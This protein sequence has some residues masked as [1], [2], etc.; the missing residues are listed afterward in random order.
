MPTILENQ[1]SLIKKYGNTLN[2]IEKSNFIKRFLAEFIYSEALKN[3]FNITV[4]FDDVET[5]TS[6]I[7]NSCLVNRDIKNQITMMLFKLSKSEFKTEIKGPI[8]CFFPA[9]MPDSETTMALTSF[10]ICFRFNQTETLSEGAKSLIIESGFKAII[11]YQNNE[12]FCA[13]ITT[14]LKS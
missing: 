9:L 14:I 1:V 10:G 5:T 7:G 11:D 13:D 3:A 8:V 2:N 12:C 4:L 6:A